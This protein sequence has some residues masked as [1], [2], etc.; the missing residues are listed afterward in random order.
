MVQ[1]VPATC[2]FAGSAGRSSG[3]MMWKLLPRPILLVTLT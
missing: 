3:K 2:P 1:E